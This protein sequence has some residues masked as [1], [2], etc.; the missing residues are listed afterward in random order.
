MERGVKWCGFLRLTSI[1]NASACNYTIWSKV[2]KI[3]VREKQMLT[4]KSATQTF[5]RRTLGEALGVV[6]DHQIKDA[7]ISG[8]DWKGIRT[9]AISKSNVQISPV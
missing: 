7:L 3:C 4:I 2:Q 6:K 5:T 1:D 8:P 9:H